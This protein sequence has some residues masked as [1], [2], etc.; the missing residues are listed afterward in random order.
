MAHPGMAPIFA[1]GKETSSGAYRSTLDLNMPGDWVI[2]LHIKLP[3]GETVERQIEVKG[4][5]PN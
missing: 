5:R 4:V 2:Q 1:K 3:T